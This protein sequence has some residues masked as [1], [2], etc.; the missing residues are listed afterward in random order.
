[1]RLH[2]SVLQLALACREG[3]GSGLFS[4][5]RSSAK[6]GAR[7]WV[8]KRRH[9]ARRGTS[10]PLRIPTDKDTIDGYVE[11]LK[12]LTAS[13]STRLY[14]D[15]SFLVWLTALGA[16]ARAEFA[17]WAKAC[18]PGRVHV[19]VWAAHE[20]F[21][22]HVTDLHGKKMA[23]VASELNRLADETYRTL[24]PY[25]DA[26]VAG[27]PRTPAVRI[28]SAR[29]SLIEIKQ[30]AEIA[31]G[32]KKEHYEAN[33]REVITLINEIGLDSPPLLD[34][35]N[36][37]QEVERARYEGRIPPGFQDRS[38]EGADGVGSNSFGDLIFWKEILDHARKVRA[39]GIVVLSNDGKNDWIMGGQE[40]PDLDA[41]LK[42]VAKKLSPLP[43][44]HP[45]LVYEA[46]SAAAVTDLMLVNHEYLAIYLRRTGAQSERLFGAAVDV[47][48]PSA[49]QEQKTKQKR[50]RDEA[51]GRSRPTGSGVPSN[52]PKH[53]AVDDSPNIADTGLALRLAL[54]KS[55]TA[56][57]AQTSPLL[58]RMLAS[59]GEGLDG[60]LTADE[61]SG[62]DNASALWFARSLAQKAIEGNALAL[63]FCT[64]I[65]GV[66]DRLPPKTATLIY[67][68]FL[69]AAYLDGELVRTVPTAPWLPQL[70]G[71]QTHPRAQVAIGAFRKHMATRQGRPVY[72]PNADAPS[73]SV[74]P[75]VETAAGGP[76]RLVG[77]QIAGVGVLVE[78]QDDAALRLSSRFPDRSSVTLV[79]VVRDVCST[80]G[81]PFSQIEPHDAME[82]PISFGTTVGIAGEADL[83]NSM[84][85]E[86]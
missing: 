71:L 64:D 27:D 26:P 74:K 82:R 11:A 21:R 20:Y 86:A 19:P 56:E 4:Q 39:S 23:G 35:M 65:L 40:Q 73:L 1:M 43:R 46:K 32:W 3:G 49:R 52:G 61:L 41:E 54:T 8:A 17:D 30:V 62:W 22:H 48:L 6:R 77:L 10:V 51:V 33:A 60:F 12:A 15:T 31:A 38:K 59:E 81:I 80:L 84:E 42:V 16:E 72:L 24:R 29:S 47:T 83:Q 14:I 58:A 57:N 45:M 66:F 28:A 67:L 9:E 78:P 68:G 2:L 44:P 36:D 79:E 76:S 69:T 50:V 75:R 70:L 13:T 25:L 55:A 18:A 85:E 34:W 5:W 7:E 37:I 63:T 53:L